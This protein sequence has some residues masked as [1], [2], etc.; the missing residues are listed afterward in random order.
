MI[1]L[2]TKY[3]GFGTADEEDLF[4]KSDIAILTMNFPF[5]IGS[6]SVNPIC[7]PVNI[8]SVRFWK[9]LRK[10]T[11]AGKIWHCDELNAISP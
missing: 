10:Y 6:Y 1:V 8:D 5:E 3:L 11:I 2:T 9:N 7:L 4:F